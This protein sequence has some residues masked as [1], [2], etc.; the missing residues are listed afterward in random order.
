MPGCFLP[1]FI[2][3][4]VGTIA[5]SGDGFAERQRGTFGVGEIRR[6]LPGGNTEQ[7]FDGFARLPEAISHIDAH[8]A[9]VDLARPQVDEVQSSPSYATL[10][11]GFRKRLESFGRSG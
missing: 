5:D 7:T 4:C 9:A 8:A 1:D 6:V 11:R 3:H 2:R 10:L